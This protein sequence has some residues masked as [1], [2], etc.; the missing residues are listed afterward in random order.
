MDARQ[1]KPIGAL[2]PLQDLM[3]HAVESPS[4]VI[5]AQYLLFHPD[6]PPDL[7]NAK[8]LASILAR[9]PSG[10]LSDQD[11]CFLEGALPCQP[12]WTVL[13]VRPPEGGSPMALVFF[14]L[15]L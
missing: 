6:P 13:K 1:D 5:L 2:V 15:T 7:G 4:D 12:H 11:R 8:T 10:Q 14:V 9:V 3:G